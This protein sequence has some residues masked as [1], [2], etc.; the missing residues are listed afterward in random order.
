MQTQEV[1]FKVTVTYK[2][3]ENRKDDII[4]CESFG[5]MEGSCMIAFYSP[6]NKDNMP[7]KMINEDIV[8]SVNV[9][10]MRKK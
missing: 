10:R 8:A 4:L 3:S 9:I 6:D 5:P 2:T 1:I 7:D